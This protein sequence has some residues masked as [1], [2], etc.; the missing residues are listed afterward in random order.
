MND[1]S[2]EHN[3][4]IDN[5]INS[6]L[7]LH[8]DD[9]QSFKSEKQLREKLKSI[10]AEYLDSFYIFGYDIDGKTILIKGA[11]SDMQKDALDTLAMRLFVAGNLGGT[12]GGDETKY[13]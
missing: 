4:D 2:E 3:K 7:N 1:N 9:L 13:R 8:S 11:K 10:V 12:Y 5:L 6:A